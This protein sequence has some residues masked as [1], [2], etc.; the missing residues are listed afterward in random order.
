MPHFRSAKAT[1]GREA[2]RSV[3]ARS[4]DRRAAK[5]RSPREATT[6][7]LTLLVPAI[8]FGRHE[9][10]GACSGRAESVGRALL[11]PPSLQ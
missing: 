4:A 9:A 5:P 3:R 1:R 7:V 2:T 8:S 6:R 10:N 11:C